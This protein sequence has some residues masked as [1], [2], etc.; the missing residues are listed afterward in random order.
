M[1]TDDTPADDTVSF[2]SNQ[3]EQAL[4]TA[5]ARSREDAAEENEEAGTE[6]ISI[7]IAALRE[8]DLWVPLPEGAGQQDD[9]SVALP[10][11]DLEGSTFIPAFTS[12]SQLNVRS[13]ELPYTIIATREL[14]GILPEGVGLALNP[15]NTTGVPIY[16]E[17]VSALAGE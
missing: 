9:G 5:L 1:S 12:E 8:G 15:G 11:L 3:V 6:A 17:T 10:T 2:P 7:F 14:A 4:D 16:P 13:G